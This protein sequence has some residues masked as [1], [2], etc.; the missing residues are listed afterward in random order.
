MKNLGNHKR[1][2]TNHQAVKPTNNFYH[3][4]LSSPL[5][6]YL[7]PTECN[8]YDEDKGVIHICKMGCDQ[9][10]IYYDIREYSLIKTNI[11]TC[12]VEPSGA[13]CF[14][15]QDMVNGKHT[16]I[17]IHEEFTKDDIEF[18][19]PIKL[20][21]DVVALPFVEGRRFISWLKHISI[22]KSMEKPRYADIY[23]QTEENNLSRI[24]ARTLQEY[25]AAVTH[26]K[27]L[28]DSFPAAVWLELKEPLDDVLYKQLIIEDENEDD[29]EELVFR[30][31]TM[32]DGILSPI[33]QFNVIFHDVKD[34]I[35]VF[36]H[37]ENKDLLHKL[38]PM[39]RKHSISDILK[40]V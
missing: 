22:I 36:S 21:K 12:S 23:L 30:L 38:S 18:L 7:K 14:R 37:H 4:T 8:I 25:Q 3:L 9:T 39:L 27:Y 26:I 40:A 13:I 6:E 11:V 20:S 1:T 35:R 29:E 28:I 10:R 31:S 34:Q 17:F 15:I 2:K 33:H 5:F 24:H 32:K 19:F 16:T